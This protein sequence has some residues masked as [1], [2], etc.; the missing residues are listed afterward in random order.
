MIEM[1]IGI[2][3][4]NCIMTFMLVCFTILVYNKWGFGTNTPCR[5]LHFLKMWRE[6]YFGKINSC[7]KL[8]VH[9]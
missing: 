4:P 9:T 5:S 8:Q 2:V 6:K 7:K 3:V 1:G